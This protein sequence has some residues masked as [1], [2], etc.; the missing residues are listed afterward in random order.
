MRLQKA[1]VTSFRCVDDSTEFT[2][3]DITCLVGKNEAGKSTLL[4]ALYRLNPHIE[5]HAKF[6][7]QNDY[8]RRS[9]LDFDE[10]HPKGTAA[11]AI[12]TWWDL[13]EEDVE[14][15]EQVL[16]EKAL[17]TNQI[18]VCRGYTGGLIWE[19]DVDEQVVLDHLIAEAGLHAEEAVEAKKSGSVEQLKKWLEQQSANGSERHKALQALL[20]KGF[21]R[22]KAG[23]AAVDILSERMPKFVFFSQY[24]RMLGQVSLE[25]VSQH[26]AQGTLSQDERVF[27]A[28]LALVG[29]STKE[30]AALTQFEPMIARL[31]AASIKISKE[32]FNYW[33]QNRHLKVQFRLDTGKAGDPAPYNSGTV[34][35]TRV[36]NMHHDVTV[37]FDDRSTGF[38]W[39]FSFL[40]LFSQVRK[41]HGDRL[42]ILL[43]EPGL[44]L[45]AKAQTDLLRYFEEKL[46]PKYQV[47]YSTHS[48]FMVPT[49]NLMCTRTVEDIVKR[50]P[51]GQ[52]TEVLGTKVSGDALSTDRDTL[53][54]LQGALGYEITQSLFVGKH[55]LLVEGP[56]DLLYLKAFSEELR[57][58]GK[59][60]LDARW[61]ICPTGGV[62]KVAA[63][64]AL[65]GGNRLN[66][67]VLVD[68]AT[69]QKK[70]VDEF[71]RMRLLSENRIL[72]ANTYAGQAEGD[73]E[74]ILGK[75]MYP[76][77]VNAAYGLQGAQQVSAGASSGPLRIL[78]HVEG[79]FRT[80]PAGSPE[81]DHFTPSDHLVQNRAKLFSA[82][83]DASAAVDRFE[84]LI[85]D[86]NALL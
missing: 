5:A 79:H 82:L 61:V 62:D 64:M 22:G 50:G 65:F 86:I 76:A 52:V 33:T 69:G 41:T 68:L 29:A 81:F 40:V 55:T 34:L 66:V 36:L 35:R 3:D 80:L 16:G 67:A 46:K 30:L 72:T 74:D 18:Q 83:P 24:D 20:D 54:P 47:V 8:P 23:L 9:L 71:R 63:F 1:R 12:R 26:E 4:Q 37:G 45:H 56:S 39:F 49:D 48:P 60:P 57:A 51:D 58:R 85:K 78:E 32:I 70:K 19:L 73:S 28:F 7:K 10:R 75:Q 53:F 44:S 25:E 84:R 13:S 27:L 14:V 43:D 77:L 59:T 31:E 6:D 21:K 38:V 15:V 17:K 42:V 2:L 11:T